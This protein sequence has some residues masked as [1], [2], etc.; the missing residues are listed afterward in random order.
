MSKEIEI[1]FVSENVSKY[2]ELLE[3]VNQNNLPL[4]LTLYKPSQEIYE[5]QSLDRKLIVSEKLLAAY[6]EF[7]RHNGLRHITSI[8]KWLMVEDTSFNITKLG[9]FPGPFVKF[10]LQSLPL[11]E[12][13]NSNWASPADAIVSLGISKICPSGEIVPLVFEGVIS[14]NI[15]SPI[16]NNGF[17][18]DAIFRPSGQNLTYAEMT[19]NEKSIYSPRI[20]AFQKVVNYLC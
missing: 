20:Q 11:N 5:V 1:I 8:D 2:Q 16:G 9:G 3:W 4:K 12:I 19:N 15:V 7:M 14:G 13:A 18:F 10:Y 6:N 17:G